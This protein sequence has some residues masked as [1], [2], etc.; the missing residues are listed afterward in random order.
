MV[1]KELKAYIRPTFLNTVIQELE[2]AGA[3]DMTVLR[4]DALGALADSEF[5][6]WHIVRKYDEKYYR[7]AKLEIV[8]EDDD[9]GRF[10]EIIREHGHTGEKGDGRVFV[11]WIEDAVNIRTGQRGEDAL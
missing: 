9:A 3:K 1:V 8:C 10:V 2:K 11:S 5:D 6:R 7:V 4:V